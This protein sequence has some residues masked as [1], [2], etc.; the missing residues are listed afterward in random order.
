M[1]QLIAGSLCA[2]ALLAVTAAAYL[3]LGLMEVAADARPA[4]WEAGLMTS[5]VHA[6]VRRRAA[7]VR[8]PLL[9]ADADLV[10][11][12]K[13]YLNDCVGCHGAPG[14]PPS[15]YGVTFF[16]PAPQF[17]HSASRYS[18]AELFWVAKHGIRM[19]GM[20]PQAPHYS[21]ADL[22]RLAAFI[23]RIRNLPPAVVR[24]LR[25]PASPALH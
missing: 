11:G 15:D 18:A 3:A 12:G 20:Y 2:L 17:P 23:D 24:A 1:K 5:A 4:A 7:A 21:D 9:Q 14:K 25:A 10:A 6:S 13:L 16:P 22:W 8:H 19:S